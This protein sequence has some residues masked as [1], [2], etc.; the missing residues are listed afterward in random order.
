M[1]PM[2]TR[3]RLAIDYTR[4]ALGLTPSNSPRLSTR[5]QD[6]F[7]YTCVD[8]GRQVTNAQ[9]NSTMSLGYI[10]ATAQRAIKDKCGNC[11]EYAAVVF[12]FLYLVGTE[13]LTLELAAYRIPGD[14]VFVVLGRK[15]GKKH[16][17][18]TWNDDA[19]IADA[20]SNRIVKPKRYF[21]DM[22]RHP[23]R[24]HQPIINFRYEPPQSCQDGAPGAE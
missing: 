3:A 21:V 23:R 14:H 16:K 17:P 9:H 22:V 6:H 18:L 15:S 12:D 13:G 20:W 4:G 19:L 11:L 1:E 5:S 10:R 24:V 7:W 2:E 8:P